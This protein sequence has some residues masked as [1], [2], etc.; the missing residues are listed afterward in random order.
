MAVVNR[1][2]YEGKPEKGDPGIEFWGNSFVA[3]PTGQMVAEASN[4]K[5]EILVVE[6]DAA[7]SEDT[8]RNWPF[9]RDRRIDAF[10]GLTSRW[11]G[12]K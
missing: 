1:V 8:R 4:D 12:E 7:K 2:G 5:E 9:F 6:C 11:L 3:D 10:G